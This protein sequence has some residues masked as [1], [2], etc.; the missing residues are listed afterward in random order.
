MTQTEIHAL[1]QRQRDYFS[2]GATLPVENRI[3]LLKNLRIALTVHEADITAAV[4]ADL[5]KCATE[6]FMCE[7]GLV[8]SELSYMLSHIRRFARE[9]N[10]LSPLAQ[11]PSRSYRKPCP[12]GV[13]LIMSPWNYPVLLTLCPL[14]SAVAA[15][16]TAIVK[17]SAYSPATTALLAQILG[18]VFDPG[19]VTLV[20]GGREENNALL[21]EKFV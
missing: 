8:I 12:Y 15:G 21:E 10:V 17:P 13:T 1:V 6:T 11:F 20:T 7:T 2:T 18:D 14:V 4:E 5:G 19:H 16:N 3:R 9:Q